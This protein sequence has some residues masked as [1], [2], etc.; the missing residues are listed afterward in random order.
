MPEVSISLHATQCA[1]CGT[2]DN[3]R[4]LY[5]ATVTEAAFDARTFSA[6]RLPDRV[7]YRVVKCN[8]CGLVRS[9]PVAASEVQ[10]RLYAESTVDYSDE[11]ANLRRTY[12][13]YLATVSA[14][15]P[16]KGPLLEIGCGNGF[17][18]EQAMAQG[19]TQVHG[20]E[21]SR[22]AVDGALPGL[23]SRIICD[24]MRPGL[25]P[26]ETF[27][28][29]CL[30]QTFDHVPDPSGML[31]ET[32]SLLKPGGLVLALNH[33][34]DALSARLLGEKSPIVDVEHPFLYSKRTMARIFEDHGFRVRQIRPA[35]NQYT[36]QYL[37]RLLPIPDR[38]KGVVRSLINDRA[39]G[40]LR[41]RV[42]LGNLVLLAE[43]PVPH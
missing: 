19:F 35:T 18:L 10:A 24:V 2:A 23:R 32:F 21:P 29:I 27:S 4:Q 7:H 34:V 41:V 1:I 33:N 39:V 43:K 3:A 13:R 31:R 17:F 6:R 42:P 16:E 11:T 28:V 36:V 37:A 40:R 20:V 9:D 30:F 25:F 8:S 22:A 12:G 15:L 26:P 14:F 5:P 38:A